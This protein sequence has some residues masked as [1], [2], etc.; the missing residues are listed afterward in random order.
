MWYVSEKILVNENRNELKKVYEEKF[1]DFY[2]D[3]E[4]YIRDVKRLKYNAYASYV[5]GTSLKMFVNYIPPYKRNDLFSS[6]IQT[7][8]HEELH[9]ILYR[10]EG[11]DATKGLDIID[12]DGDISGYSL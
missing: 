8:T 11:W 2:P 12:M 4:T 1:R 6:V 7:V 3:Y 10:N 9:E 5:I